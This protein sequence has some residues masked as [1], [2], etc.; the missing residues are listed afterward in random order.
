MP[1]ATHSRD[2]CGH[3]APTCAACKDLGTIPHED[4]TLPC[5]Y[6]NP[7]GAREAAAIYNPKE[8]S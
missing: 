1:S 8:E 2:D 6:C 4:G 3:G 7:A 5:P